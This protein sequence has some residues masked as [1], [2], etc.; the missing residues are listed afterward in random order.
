[1][2]DKPCQLA[3]RYHNLWNSTHKVQHL[4]NN[5]DFY[6]YNEMIQKS[7]QSML[8]VPP[9]MVEAYKPVVRFKAGRHHMYVQAKKDP[10]Q[11]WFPTWYKLTEEEMG[12]IM[13]DSDVD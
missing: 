9:Q 1:M 4:D 3:A 8:H 13:A 10:N 6:I 2:R 5:V 7:I 12:H 11:Q